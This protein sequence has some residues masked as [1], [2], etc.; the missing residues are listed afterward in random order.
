MQR[1]VVESVGADAEPGTLVA[2]IAATKKSGAPAVSWRHGDPVDVAGDRIGPA[3]T[4]REVTVIERG[5]PGLERQ[6]V[7]DAIHR[8]STQLSGLLHRAPDA[9]LGASIVLGAQPGSA[10]KDEGRENCGRPAE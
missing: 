7:A 8:Q 10:N 5:D 6:Q 9:R 2:E 1:Q 3:A 4:D